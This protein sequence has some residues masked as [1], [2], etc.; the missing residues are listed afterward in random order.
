MIRS[1]ADRVFQLSVPRQRLGLRENITSGVRLLSKTD[2]G[3]KFFADQDTSRLHPVY[4]EASTCD[5]HYCQI[6][7]SSFSVAVKLNPNLLMATPN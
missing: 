3:F 1:A 7:N 5:F 6:S 4:T 2:G